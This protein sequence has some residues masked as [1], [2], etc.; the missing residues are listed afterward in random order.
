MAQLTAGTCLSRFTETKV[1][2]PMATF[3]QSPYLHKS[4]IIIMTSFSL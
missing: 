3:R 1:L 2:Q 4:A